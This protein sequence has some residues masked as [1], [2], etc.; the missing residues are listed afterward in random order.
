VLRHA[1]FQNNLLDRS[2]QF[3]KPRCGNVEIS[4]IREVGRG[5]CD[6][7][8]GGRVGKPEE[9]NGFG[10]LRFI[11]CDFLLLRGKSLPA[12]SEVPAILTE[13]QLAG[14][15]RVTISRKHSRS[16]KGR[17]KQRLRSFFMIP[18]P[19][20]YMANQTPWRILCWSKCQ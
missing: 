12:G 17:Q 2:N 15:S 8:C 13:Q 1:F 3:F 7:V 10:H 19:Q 5:V 6:K 20:V 18:M 14:E 9:S 11:L 4:V 16:Y